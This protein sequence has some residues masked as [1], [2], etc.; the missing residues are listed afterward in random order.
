MSIFKKMLFLVVGCVVGIAIP[1]TVVGYFLISD[2][3]DS[4]AQKE[5]DMSSGSMQEIVDDALRAQQGYGDFLE[6]DREFAEAIA[7]GDAAAVKA[8]AAKFLD[9]P[10]VDL[11]TVCDA[12]GKV[13][14]RGHSDK[15]GDV[16]GESRRSAWVPLREGR[17]ITG[18]E[19][20][21]VVLLTLA[22][23]VPIRS[24]N[25]VVGVA[26]LGMDLSSGDLVGRIKAATS[27]ECTIFLGDTRASTTVI[28]DG[29]P[30]VGTRLGNQAIQD[31]VLRDGKKTRTRNLIGGA[32]YDTIYWPWQDMD[33]KNAGMFFVGLSRA[34]ITAVQT[35]A[36]VVFAAC[37]GV[38]GLLMIFLGVLVAR[39]ISRPVR[40]ATA[41]AQEVA[42]GNFDGSLNIVTRDEV[43]VLAGALSTMVGNLKGKIAEAEDTSHEAEAQA[44]KALA[45]MEE[46]G[47]ATERAEQSR[48]SIL[49]AAEN[50]DQVTQRLSAAAEQLSGQVA[51]SARSAENQRSRVVNSATAMEEMN[52][53]VLEVARSA[54]TAAEGTER[55]KEKARE[56]EGIVR[57]TIQAING[58][59]QE[60]LHLREEMN[61]LGAQA[62]NIGAIMT[63]IS[64]IADQ[65]NLL[66]L[67]AAIEAARAGEAG[68]GFA[69]VADE[70]R[71]LAEKTM[72][73]T[74]EVAEAIG[75]IQASSRESIQA[76]AR[77]GEGLE[78]AAEYVGR[79][80]GALEEIVA[81]TSTMADQVRG[82][83]TAAEEQSASSEEI[84]RS[85]EEINN[86]AAE[87]AAIM[88]ESADAVS[89][90]TGQARELQ[91]LVNRLR[92]SS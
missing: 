8:R 63:V 18:I 30:F 67:N 23:G 36:I 92:S 37:G 50:V 28:R 55:A 66:A 79:S 35:R 76:T 13:I 54:S 2:M 75:G 86:D 56:G 74:R 53:T 5:L 70:V 1:L 87:T 61:R 52:A 64:D 69:V 22:T 91:T 44:A 72:G 14:A 77:T 82:I 51:S 62:E 83:A 32:E 80:G 24:G 25:T 71:K 7:M 41:Y 49:T 17:R 89:E 4:S 12:S 19:P 68:R 9:S 59:Q 20:G 16:L 65:T 29:K 45:A 81:E 10:M 60:T 33:G 21:N 6:A 15:A 78:K 84:T 85:L 73:A 3:G 90:L 11:V 57:E 31:A 34:D 39:T 26:I 58:V 48:Q 46:A 42:T 38:I 43:G 27:A 88:N 40:A 47:K